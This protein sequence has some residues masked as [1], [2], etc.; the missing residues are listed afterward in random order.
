M[1]GKLILVGFVCLAALPSC[2]HPVEQTMR[3]SM[4]ARQQQ[5][6]ATGSVSQGASDDVGKYY[7]NDRNSLAQLTM[8]QSPDSLTANLYLH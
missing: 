6:M 3:A 7:Q 4:E 8:Q 5:L 2:M 1:R